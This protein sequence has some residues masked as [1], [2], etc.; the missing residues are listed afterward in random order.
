MIQIKKTDEVT[1]AD[2]AEL[3]PLNNPFLKKSFLSALEK[4][5]SVGSSAGWVPLYFSEADGLLYTFLKTHSYGEYIFDWDW[6]RAF[7]QC[8]VAYYPKLTS[9]IP[10]TPVTTSHFIMPK[11]NFDVASRLMDSYLK[12]YE[13]HEFSSSH[14]LFITEEEIPLFENKKH[15]IRESFQ[16]HFFNENYVSF[17][18]YLLKMKP[19]KAKNIRQER[20]FSDLKIEKLTSNLLTKRHAGEMYQLY[21]STIE[22]KNAID[23]LKEEFFKIVFH[24]MKENL[25]FVR[26][27]SDERLVAGSLFFYDRERLY[28]RYW[29]TLEKVE[30]LHF[31]LCYYQGIEFTIERKLKVFEAGAQGEHKISRGFRPVKTFSAHHIKNNAFHIG[32]TNY[33]EEE[34]KHI[35]RTIEELTKHLPFKTSR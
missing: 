15:M 35:Q 19:K 33:I 14:F 2:W 32:I 25:L 21:L 34:K 1:D 4:S 18:D 28:G 12:F 10:L 13:M 17:E 27:S 3:Q 20:Q 29:G 11:F 6:A 8:Q 16:Y 5:Q 9:M 30:N 26:A 7:S 23:Y 24:E 22:D 31:E